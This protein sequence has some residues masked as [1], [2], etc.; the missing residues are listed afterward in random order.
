M[1]SDSVLTPQDS[2]LK[3]SQRL[4]TTKTAMPHAAFAGRKKDHKNGVIAMPTKRRNN[5]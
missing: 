4:K 5:E 2:K 1:F 3:K